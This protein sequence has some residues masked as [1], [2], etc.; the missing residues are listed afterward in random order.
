VRPDVIKEPAQ[1]EDQDRF[2]DM[3]ARIVSE[4]LP[5]TDSELELVETMAVAKWRQKR[6]WAMESARVSEEIRNQSGTT[7]SQLKPRSS[8]P[9]LPSKPSSIAPT[10][11]ARSIATKSAS[12]ASTPAAKESSGNP[13]KENTPVPNKPRFS[14][15]FAVSMWDRRFRLSIRGLNRYPSVADNETP[16]TRTL[17]L[18]NTKTPALRLR[19]FTF[20]G[21]PARLSACELC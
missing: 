21:T 9:C 15:V 13:G 19:V 11:S 8:A 20:L 16:T 1:G 18:Y 6:I 12:I 4:H 3:L 10:A 14:F 7:N 5:Q 2:N 17:G